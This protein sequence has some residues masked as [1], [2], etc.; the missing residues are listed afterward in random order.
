MCYFLRVFPLFLLL[1]SSFVLATAVNDVNYIGSKT[2]ATCHQQE[3]TDWQGSHHDQAMMHANKETVLGDFN[4]SRFEYN[5][6]T[7]T[8]FEKDDEFWVNTDD[9][10]G[11]LRDFKIGYTFGVNP[12]QQYLIGFDD[13]RF[14]AL[15]IA[16]DSRL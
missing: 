15:G 2:C 8:F 6:I 11:E 10:N 14:Q 5:G 3:F 12:L 4:N 13:G 9:E 16:W 7:T 1:N